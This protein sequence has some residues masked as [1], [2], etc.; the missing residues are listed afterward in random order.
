MRSRLTSLL[1]VAPLIATGVAL[2]DAAPA[3]AEDAGVCTLVTRDEA[4]DLLGAKV[5]KTTRKTSAK[6][7]AEEC[8]YKTKKVD[9]D[10]GKRNLKISL[11]LTVQPVTDEVRSELQNI[12]FEDG[13]RVQGLGD[14]A[15]V[16]KFDQVIA[17]SGDKAVAAKLQN[18]RGASTKFR[19]VSEGA[20]RA[21]LPRLGQLP[22]PT[23]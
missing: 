1:L 4:G 12:P 21:A 19:N 16:T 7:G 23:S 17:I 15:Y 18:Y 20:V 2:L 6:T 5:V 13:S 8:T 22:P 14:E 9:K 10:L 3:A 11:E